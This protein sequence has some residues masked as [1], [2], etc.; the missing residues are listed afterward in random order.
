MQE[1]HKAHVHSW[2]TGLS[3]SGSPSAALATGSSQR[4]QPVQKDVHVP[5]AR[6]DTLRWIRCQKAAHKT[7][8]KHVWPHMGSPRDA[9][10]SGS[11]LRPHSD[12]GV[13]VHPERCRLLGVTAA[14]GDVSRGPRGCGM[15]RWQQGPASLLWDTFT[16]TGHGSSEG[17]QG[18]PLPPHKA[19]A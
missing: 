3:G 19:P 11:A 12:G 9:A 4:G 13:S 2:A 5:S 8:G 10:P 16:N 15:G 18:C 14:G 6:A 1:G 7:G 17:G